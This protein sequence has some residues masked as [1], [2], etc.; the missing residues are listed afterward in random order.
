MAKYQK[1]VD[2]R[3]KAID[4]KQVKI[5][6]QQK[7]IDQINKEYQKLMKELE[8]SD[9]SLQ[10]LESILEEHKDELI[11]INLA[12]WSSG[13]LRFAYTGPLIKPT[14]VTKTSS[15]GYRVHPIFGTRKNFT[16]E[17]ITEDR[18]ALRSR[19]QLTV[20]WCPAVRLPDMVG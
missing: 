19:P 17:W 3:Q 4:E 12:E 6:E 18:S 13:K 16:R 11:Q 14:T 5:E 15:Y 1:A 2:D 7:L 9:A 20:S 10:Q 8:A